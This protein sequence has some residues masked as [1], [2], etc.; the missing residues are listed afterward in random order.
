MTVITLTFVG[1]E[2]EIVSG[3][4][5]FMTIESNVPATIHF[6]LDG[7]T[8][9]TDSPIF[10]DTFEMP[11]NKNSVTL[12]AF[13]IDSENNTSP[14]LTQVFAPDTTRITVSRR[15]GLEGFV[16]DRATDDTD[17]VVG[18]GADGEPVAFTDFST[19]FLNL[20]LIRSE[21]GLHGIADGTQVEVSMPD[22]D[23]TIT[24]SD[25]GFTPFSTPEVGELFNPEARFILIDNRKDNDIDIA[26]KPYGSL[27]NVYEEFG[28]K[29]LLHPADDATY[30]SGGHVR[31]FFNSKNKTMVTYY[32]DHNESR[33]VKNI[34]KLPEGIPAVNYGSTAHLPI[35][36]P[37]IHPGKQTG[38]II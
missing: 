24:T 3:I 22:P 10:V 31:R 33:W 29:R 15:V 27:H 32:F 17:N 30:V 8:P 28:G 9:T 25:D 13:G 23:S 37:W 34:Q 36:F 21:K 4:P 38:T 7:S 35:I 18:F 26:L 12:S 6:T 16:I 11:D 5:R 14:I 2:E 19:S 1:S 20:R